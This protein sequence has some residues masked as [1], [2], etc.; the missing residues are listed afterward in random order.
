MWELWKGKVHH[1]LD[2]CP[3]VRGSREGNQ[4][5]INVLIIAS[6]NCGSELCWEMLVFSFWSESTRFASSFFSFIKLSYTSLQW[7]AFNVVVLQ[8][9]RLHPQGKGGPKATFC[10]RRTKSSQIHGWRILT[11]Y[12][13]FKFKILP[14]TCHKFADFSKI[15][16]DRKAWLTDG[17]G[18]T[19]E[20]RFFWPSLHKK[21][22]RGKK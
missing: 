15:E 9:T 7:L 3:S 4:L 13:K 2:S 5:I 18:R 12:T 8:L 11:L 16:R 6:S 22:L 21:P 14:I 17:H 19:H 20:H 10:V 1:K